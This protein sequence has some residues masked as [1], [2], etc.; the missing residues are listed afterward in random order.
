MEAISAILAYTRLCPQ[1]HAMKPQNRRAVPPSVRE[2]PRY[3]PLL[4]EEERAKDVR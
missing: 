2:K 3:L 1:A 4:G